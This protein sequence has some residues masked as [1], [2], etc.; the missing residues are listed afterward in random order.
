MHDIR[1]TTILFIRMTPEESEIP[2]VKATAPPT[3]P[4][5][6]EVQ[7]GGL[8]PPNHGIVP[9]PPQ[10][11]LPDFSS[12][13]KWAVFAVIQRDSASLMALP[14]PI[15]ELYNRD[16]NSVQLVSGSAPGINLPWIFWDLVPSISA[17]GQWIAYTSVSNDP[18]IDGSYCVSSSGLTC[19]DIFLYNRESGQ[20]IRITQSSARGAANGVSFSPTVSADGEW[21][22]FWSAASN[23]VEGTQ[24]TCEVDQNVSCLYVYLYNK[25]SG[26]IEQIPI[27]TAA[28]GYLIGA[29]RISL[30]ADARFIGFTVT[31][32]KLAQLQGG[33]NQSGN[34][35]SNSSQTTIEP[36]L[37]IDWNNSEAIVYDRETGKYEGENQ[38]QAGIH[39][40]ADSFS[41]MLSDDGRFVAFSSDSSDL[42]PGDSNSHT[43]VFIRDRTNGR[44]ELISH[45][46]D[47][48]PGDGQSGLAI[49]SGYGLNIS[50]DG[51]YI[52]YSSYA[53]NISRPAPIECDPE[54]WTCNFIYLYDRE[55]R[56]NILIDDPP[57]YIFTFF[58]QVSLDGNWA[59]FMQT[60]TSGPYH[61]YQNSDVMLYDRQQAWTTNLTK[62][63]EGIAGTPWS[64]KGSISISSEI[65]E[66]NALAFSPDGSLLALASNDSFVR[67][68]RVSNGVYSF[69]Q[70]NP[71]KMLGGGEQTSYTS[72]AFSPDGTLLAAGTT[73]RKAFIW[74]LPDDNLLYSLEVESGPVKD[75]KFSA[76]GSQLVVSGSTDVEIWRFET[77]QIAMASSFS[78]GL[79]SIYD[80]AI[81]PTGNFVATARSNGT[82]W[83]QSIPSGQ[84]VSRLGGSKAA[85]RE[86]I[87]SSDGN[88]LATCST[89]GKMNIWNING[90]L[91]GSNQISLL[92][93]FQTDNQF[94]PISFSSDNRYLATSSLSGGVL[95]WD[96]Y[97][98][99]IYKLLPSNPDGRLD[100][101]A[102]SPWGDELAGTLIN[103]DLVLWGLTHGSSS[104]Y[105]VHANQNNYGDSGP[106]PFATANDVLMLR[107]STGRSVNEHLTLDQA[108]A[109]L[110]FPLQVPA[111]LPKNIVFKE[112]SVNLD[113]SAW[114]EYDASDQGKI[115]AGLYIYEQY[116]G[117]TQ[118]PTMTIGASGAVIQ[119]PIASA[120]GI[121]IAEYVQGDWIW[122]RY[123]NSQTNT[124]NDIWDWYV[125]KPTQ[126]L[127]WRQQGIFIAMYYQVT[128]PF[129]RV[130][131]QPVQNEFVPLDNVLTQQDL[132]QIA[133]GML[134]IP[135][136][137]GLTLYDTSNPI[138]IDNL[139][140]LPSP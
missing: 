10:Y 136:L 116:I 59:S 110:A 132:V 89:D 96:I 134:P 51:R 81:S 62:S 3:M 86:I 64:Y 14:P 53:K 63:T 108:A 112:A 25:T 137:N 29:D 82:V 124:H 36:A 17:D 109:D 72:L 135:E 28:S 40:N 55:T 11:I 57:T 122:S 8:L 139:I 35:P 2:Q 5:V 88:L 75:V 138:S 74:K 91:T 83:L 85:I 45:A 103:S 90:L 12:D 7:A 123:Y 117:D 111:H 105:F 113:G 131:N 50:S 20:T 140:F 106:I 73:S 95:L 31:K 68:W 9:N 18:T 21:V 78:Y 93:T 102:F 32:D 76:D 52:I 48:T 69:L 114:L 15:I 71:S 34:S 43:D 4:P 41:P 47:G 26:K 61:Q 60:A 94:G 56:N 119:I 98:G 127:R 33:V 126:R 104:T 42:V 80:I 129:E 79:T 22:A 6:I 46:P 70:S 67:T 49:W 120:S 16:T 23:L 84:V 13:G 1:R 118:P 54:G 125:M 24:V 66:R 107:E 100:S 97:N 37:P 38:T 58:P 130:T 77:D 115:Q 99:D 27:R 65:S 39:G 128:S 87:F 133:I 121:N 101:L 92:N 30:S 44:I 19:L